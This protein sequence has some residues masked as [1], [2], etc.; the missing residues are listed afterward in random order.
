MKNPRMLIPA[1]LLLF[2]GINAQSN[3]KEYWLEQ[4]IDHFNFR[5]QGTFQQRYYV[6]DSAWEK[7]GPILLYT[8]NEAP[9]D[10]F[11]QNT[12]VMWEIAPVVKG[13]IV[14]AEHRYLEPISV[15]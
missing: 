8:G 12:G 4:T 3:L 13:L 14:F 1:L 2:I 6:D 9:I 7:N 11:I 10:V 5:P 15:L